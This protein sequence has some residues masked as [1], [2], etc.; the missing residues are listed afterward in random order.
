MI[1]ANNMPIYEYECRACRHRFEQL[2]IHSTSPECPSCHARDLER[3]VSMFG[4]D[5]ETTRGSALRDGKRR[6]MQTTR[7][8]NDA[9]IAY[10]RKHDDH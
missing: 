8:H 3:L 7:E 5:S 1:A 6:Q 9:E 4:V 2:I 10:H